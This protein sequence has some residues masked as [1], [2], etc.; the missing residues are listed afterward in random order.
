MSAKEDADN[1]ISLGKELMA[2]CQTLAHQVHGKF[3]NPQLFNKEIAALSTDEIKSRL[4]LPWQKGTGKPKPSTASRRRFF[5][6]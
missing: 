5:D 6:G 3:H 4:T 1:F 2:R